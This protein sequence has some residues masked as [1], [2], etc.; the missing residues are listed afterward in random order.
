MEAS[1]PQPR[2]A[3][4]SPSRAVPGWVSGAILAAAVLVVFGRTF[5]FPFLAWDDPTAVTEN[6][7]LHPP[8]VENLVRIWSGGWSG[9]YV[10]VSFTAWWIEMRLSLLL[11]AARAPD[12]RVFHAGMLLLHVLAA[13]VVR[14]I[15]LR[16]VDDPRAALLGALLFAVHPLQTES[17]AWITE[18]RGVLASLLGL[19]ALDVHLAGTT[20]QEGPSLA[21]HHLP[22]GVLFALAVLAKP[23]AVAIPVLAFL[24]DRFRLRLPLARVLAP[25]AAGLVLVAVD[26]LVTA[27]Q[28]GGTSIRLESPLAARPLVALDALGFYLRKLVAPFHLA[29]DYGRRP[30]RLF[31]S[32]AVWW[33]ASIPIVA[34]LVLAA[35]PGRRRSLLALGLFSAALLPVLGLVRFDYQAISTVADRYAYLALLGPAFALATFASSRARIAAA[36]VLVLAFGAIAFVDV[37]RWQDTRTLFAA[38]LDVNPRSHVAWVQLGTVDEAAGRID[39]ALARYRHALE[40]EPGYPVAAGNVGRILLQQ[41]DLDGAVAILRETVRRDPDYPFAGRDLAI[42]LVRRGLKGSDERRRADFA[43]AESV[44]RTTIRAQPGFP[45]AHLTLGQLLYT[46]GHVREAASEFLATLAIVPGST[47]ALHGLELCRQKLQSG[48]AGGRP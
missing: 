28:Q 47:D 14:R 29:A 12:P 24:I 41:G 45:D 5:L 18:T 27:S 26:V 13:G 10:P 35:L 7:L 15:L 48:D 37:P 34:A 3:R 42:A 8:S 23:T 1:G 21:R 9:L 19:L 44:L 30:D 4:A 2:V 33:T 32:S 40:L 11:D 22:S 38:T 46:E 31:E 43:E 25:V 17:V 39:E 20:S 16:L 6:L 36:G